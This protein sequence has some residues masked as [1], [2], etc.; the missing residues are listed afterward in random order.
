MTIFVYAKGWKSPTKNRNFHAYF[1][2]YNKRNR[3]MGRLGMNTTLTIQ[4]N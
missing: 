3:A 1:L 2:Y 4:K